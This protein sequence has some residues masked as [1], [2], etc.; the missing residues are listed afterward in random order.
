MT[1]RQALMFIIGIIVIFITLIYL[2][3]SHGCSGRWEESG[4]RAKYSPS[5]GC[6]VEVS[7]GHWFP[8]ER[9]VTGSIK[10]E[11]TLTN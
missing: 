9:V 3:K 2:G 11:K 6:I 8:E 7:E 1:D 10:V 4:T 5:S